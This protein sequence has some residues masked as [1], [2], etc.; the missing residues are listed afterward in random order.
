M[1]KYN[2]P[3]STLVTIRV[4]SYSF[5]CNGKDEVSHPMVYLRIIPNE[6]DILCPYC[7]V[8]YMYMESKK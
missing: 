8:R 6:G 7:G 2:S 5:A 3:D 1:S 4:D